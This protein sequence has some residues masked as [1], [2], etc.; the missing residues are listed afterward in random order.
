M[1]S[2]EEDGID[3][4][5]LS[6][7][8]CLY[9]SPF[10]SLELCDKQLLY[11]PWKTSLFHISRDEKREAIFFLYIYRRGQPHFVCLNVANVAL[12]G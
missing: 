7:M 5:E 10:F 8:K 2:G 6:A 9:F 1:G 12:L 3:G 11:S 4:R